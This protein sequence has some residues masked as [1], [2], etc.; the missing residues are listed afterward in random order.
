MN[1]DNGAQTI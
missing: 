1:D